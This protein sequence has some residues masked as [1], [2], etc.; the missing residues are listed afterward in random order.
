MRAS[1]SGKATECLDDRDRRVIQEADAVPK[2]IPGRRTQHQRPLSDGE[3]GKR[4]D[5]HQPLL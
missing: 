1:D 2:H 5:A 3:G 4:A